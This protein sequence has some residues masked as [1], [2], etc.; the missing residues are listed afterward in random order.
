MQES[1]KTYKLE[2]SAKNHAESVC[3]SRLRSVIGHPL[4]VT[5]RLSA[6]YLAGSAQRMDLLLN[7]SKTMPLTIGLCTRLHTLILMMG[8]ER[9]K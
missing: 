6:A 8:T 5:R 2:A 9:S 3:R 7:L 4:N 1:K